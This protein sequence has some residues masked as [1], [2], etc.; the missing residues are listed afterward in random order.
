MATPFSTP[1]I[2]GVGNDQGIKD[3]T[4]RCVTAWYRS[5]SAR[6]SFN[7]RTC[8]TSIDAMDGNPDHDRC[9]PACP[10]P[11]SS[12]VRSA[13]SSTHRGWIAG[14]DDRPVKGT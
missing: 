1:C 12:Y 4:D 3:H 10:G 7:T 5:L 8:A 14:S 2:D 11:D 13:I 6:D 9:G